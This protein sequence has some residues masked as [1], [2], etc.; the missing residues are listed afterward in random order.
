M[1]HAYMGLDNTIDYRRFLIAI[2]LKTD[3]G[4]IP[5]VFNDF[6]SL[7]ILLFIEKLSNAI[8][9]YQQYSLYNQL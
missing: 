6:Y 4:Y 5:V 2:A 8:H 7:L 1:V 3:K 9:L